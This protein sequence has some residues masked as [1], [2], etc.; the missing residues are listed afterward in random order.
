MERSEKRAF[1]F[2]D[3]SVE[4]ELPKHNN[5]LKETFHKVND[6]FE[7]RIGFKVYKSYQTYKNARSRN[8]KK[9]R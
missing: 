8:R 3:K 6:E 5:S 1:D 4:E 2:F 9:S 7:A